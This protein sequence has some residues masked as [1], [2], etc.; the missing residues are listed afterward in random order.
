MPHASTPS[1][2]F[3]DLFA[4]QVSTYTCRLLPESVVWL[5]ANDRV[6]EAEKIIRRA[7]KLNNIAMP[8][9]ILVESHTTQAAAAVSD[10]TRRA[11]AK[12][13]SLA[14]SDEKISRNQSSYYTVFDIFRNRH[15]TINLLCI[16]LLW[17]V[18]A[19]N[20]VYIGLI[21]LLNFL[22]ILGP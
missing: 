5:H 16:I 18:M 10:R 6:A 11:G 15:S 7:A 8:D 19:F 9:K 17:S 21:G 12:S 22:R 2:P 4:L 14:T 1:T 3:A 20:W 13:R